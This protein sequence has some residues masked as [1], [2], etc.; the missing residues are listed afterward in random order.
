MKGSDNF[1]NVIEAYVNNFA[2][3][4]E[5]FAEKMKN[6]EKTIDKCI[7]YILNR[8]HKSGQNGFEDA[9]IFGMALHYYDEENIDSGKEIR[10]QVVVN[11]TVELTPE[12]IE[13]AKQ[14]AKDRVIKEEMERMTK[15]NKKKE[16]TP[17]KT[18]GTLF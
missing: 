3:R 5:V 4:N 11:H 15:K 10:G 18:K 13:T 2:A 9:E 12:E 16:G 1:K 17:A 8:V 6:P 14:E 7:N